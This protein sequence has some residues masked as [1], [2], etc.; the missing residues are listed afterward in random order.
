MTASGGSCLGPH[1]AQ[2]CGPHQAGGAL[3]SAAREASEVHPTPT[4]FLEVLPCSEHSTVFSSRTQ[5]LMD[6]GQSK[7]EVNKLWPVCAESSR[8]VFVNKVLLTH[9]HTHS[10]LHGLRAKGSRDTDHLALR[11]DECAEA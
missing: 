7:T 2:C 11:R 1:L 9:S 3:K 6:K 4:R 8:C 10:F 5:G